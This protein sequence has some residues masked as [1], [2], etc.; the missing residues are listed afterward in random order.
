[1]KKIYDAEYRV[2]KDE[3]KLTETQIKKYFFH[4]TGDPWFINKY[5]TGYKLYVI[6][7][8]FFDASYGDYKEIYL[9]EYEHFTISTLCHELCHSCKKARK[10]PH[11]KAWQKRYVEMAKRYISNEKGEELAEAFGKI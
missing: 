1:V 11:G 10:N 3:D 4:I 2:F 9:L 8:R 5:G 6:G 7:P